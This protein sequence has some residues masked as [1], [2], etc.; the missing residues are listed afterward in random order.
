MTVLAAFTLIVSFAA[1]YV[2]TVRRVSELRRTPRKEQPGFMLK[3]FLYW[4]LFL[5]LFVT[6]TVYFLLNGA[7]PFVGCVGAVLTGGWSILIGLA[8]IPM[9]ITFLYWWRGFRQRDV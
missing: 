9:P 7:I 8:V 3:M 5:A 2:A 4:A 6:S 1:I